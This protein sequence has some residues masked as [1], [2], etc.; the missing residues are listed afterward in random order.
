MSKPKWEYAYYLP[1]DK[2]D[3]DTVERVAGASG[4]NKS[5]SKR[6]IGKSRRASSRGERR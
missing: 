3:A 4:K 5:K 1:E 6:R 2:E